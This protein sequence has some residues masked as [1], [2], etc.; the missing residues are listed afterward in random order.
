MRIV[1]ISLLASAGALRLAIPHTKK[2]SDATSFGE[3]QQEGSKDFEE[4]KSALKKMEPYVFIR[5]HSHL[6]N[7][8][9]PTK[10]LLGA[11]SPPIRPYKSGD[12]YE[13]RAPKHAFNGKMLNTVKYKLSQGHTCEIG[14]S[15]VGDNYYDPKW[16]ADMLERRRKNSDGLWVLSDEDHF[17]ELLYHSIV[18]W[19]GL[20][21]K[22]HHSELAHM[23][24][25]VGVKYSGNNA[26][27]NSHDK[28]VLKEFMK[29]HNYTYTYPFHKTEKKEEKTPE[30]PE[31]EKP[32]HKYSS[33]KVSPRRGNVSKPECKTT[34]F[35]HIGKTGGSTVKAW[36]K[37]AYPGVRQSK[38]PKE[39]LELSEWKFNDTRFQL[40][41]HKFKLGDGGPFDCYAFFVRD[42]VERWVSGYL[43]RLRKQSH[44]DGKGVWTED[45]QVAFTRYP[46]PEA[47]AKALGSHDP[48][49]RAQAA[50]ADDA[51][52]HTRHGIS[53][54]LPKIEK[55]WDRILFVGNVHTLDTDFKR[56]CEA[57]GMPEGLPIEE[58]PHNQMPDKQAKL[59]KLS[60]KV[61]QKLKRFLKA[62][63]AVLDKL[64]KHGFLTTEDDEDAVTG[65]AEEHAT[66][67]QNRFSLLVDREDEDEV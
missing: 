13:G 59:K 2:T 33:L 34:H 67:F 18:Q 54:F 61:E 17:Y 39:S 26:N 24:K 30:T 8:E 1:F 38:S 5:D 57:A 12:F 63:Y 6:L 41:G 7:Q 50:E 28:K 58:P 21:E 55:Y 9:V 22:A 52:G 31:W 64:A 3:L 53:Y 44:G 48:N 40:H 11:D 49:E 37:R 15:K 20:P 14:F 46:K 4:L 29:E 43:S 19:P 47:L 45:E 16:A 10:V 23:A 51:V 36:L 60:P 25:K 62:D 66:G 32:F 65:D 27:S 56:M 35:I 42:P